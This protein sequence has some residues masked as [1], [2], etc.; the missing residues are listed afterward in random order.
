LDRNVTPLDG[1]DM[2]AFAV[3]GIDGTPP[4]AIYG[5]FKVTIDNIGI[6]FRVKV[7]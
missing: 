5:D 1:S 3:T 2:P 6:S 4:S 7:I